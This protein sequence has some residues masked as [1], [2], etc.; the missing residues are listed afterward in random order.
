MCD[1]YK[2]SFVYIAGLLAPDIGG[3]NHL[4]ESLTI[5]PCRVLC[6]VLG[7][8]REAVVYDRQRREHTE[9]AELF[10]RAWVYQERL[11]SRHTIVFAADQVYWDCLSCFASEVISFPVSGLNLTTF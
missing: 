1:V 3:L 5:D 8:S 4:R 7:R 10:R 2:N 9:N 11:L 6:R